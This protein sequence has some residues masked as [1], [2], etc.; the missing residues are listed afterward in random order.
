MTNVQKPL[1]LDRDIVYEEKAP[2]KEK[3]RRRP[4]I[5][6]FGGVGALLI[7]L[8]L[9]YQPESS[10]FVDSP[11]P[12][13]Q[14]ERDSIAAVFQRVQD[15]RTLN[16]S[17]PLAPDLNLPAG[18]E[19]ETEYDDVWSIRTPGGLYYTSDMEIEPFRVGEL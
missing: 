3:K 1:E 6:A 5:V 7:I 10:S 2:Q 16:D 9:L 14:L 12:E 17:M 4:G 13:E 11:P 15:F 19:F 18:F 8:V